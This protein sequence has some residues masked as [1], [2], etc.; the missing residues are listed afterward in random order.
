MSGRS[1]SSGPT[2]SVSGGRRGWLTSVCRAHRL[3]SPRL[4]APRIHCLEAPAPGPPPYTGRAEQCA[5]AH[6]T[7]LWGPE[8]CAEGPALPRTR[9]RGPFP[10][11]LPPCEW[12]LGFQGPPGRNVGHSLAQPYPLT[13][14]CGSQ[15]RQPRRPIPI[16]TGSPRWVC[17][18][19]GQRCRGTGTT[20]TPGQPAYNHRT[21]CMTGQVTAEHRTALQRN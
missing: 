19:A 2:G 12:V 8:A 4:G 13:G 21:A 15:R 9:L 20:P 16:S 18:S 17:V 14:L 10:A 11:R 3:R 6:R 5:V 1:G 7:R